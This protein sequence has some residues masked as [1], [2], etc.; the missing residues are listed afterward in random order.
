M[1]RYLSCTWHA[2]PSAFFVWY[3]SW[4][5]ISRIYRILRSTG[6]SWFSQVSIHESCLN[7]YWLGIELYIKYHA[8]DC[9]EL[10]CKCTWSL[11]YNLSK[12]LVRPAEGLF[13][14][15]WSS[16]WTLLKWNA[17]K[18]QWWGTSP[19]VPNDL[20]KY[21]HQRLAALSRGESHGFCHIHH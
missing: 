2:R 12:F 17:Q 14:L 9:S 13:N 20:I 10:S 18:Y 7:R 11:R 3:G 5:H 8:Q 21:L 6:L 1:T 16:V 19:N 15:A 4:V